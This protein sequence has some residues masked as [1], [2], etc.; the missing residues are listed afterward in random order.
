LSRTERSYDYIIL[1]V[2]T[3]DSTPGHLLSL[4]ALQAAKK[5]LQSGGILA[6]NYAGGLKEDT[7]VTASVVKTLK[8]VFD[9]VDLYPLLNLDARL[10]YGNVILLAYDGLPRSA[11]VDPAHLRDVHPMAWKGVRSGL[12]RRFRFPRGT[13]AMVLTDN[14]NPIEFFD[15][16]LKEM[17]RRHVINTTHWDVL[18]GS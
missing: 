14:Y 13:P 5:R 3:G 17:V 9:Q 7:F 8:V 11:H 2:F 18:I 6:I 1:D 15:M 16:G 10:G 12:H 4:E